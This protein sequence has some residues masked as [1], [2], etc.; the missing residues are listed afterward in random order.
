[1]S[2]AQGSVEL[3]LLDDDDYMHPVEDV[4][5]FNESAYYN[6]FDAERPVGGWV[7]IGNRPNEGYAEVTV[8][9]YEP[10]GTASFQFKRPQIANNDAHDA[11]GVRFQVVEPWKHHR[12]TY[13]GN[14]CFLRDP[15]E[16]AEPSVAFKKNPHVPVEL[17]L[18]W[19]GLS[20]GWGGEPRR[21]GPGGLWEP[22]RLGDPERQFARGHFEQHGA[23]EGS[24]EI[25]GRRYELRGCGLRDHSWGPRF[26]QNTGYYR[27]LTITLGP[28]FGLM[29]LVSETESGEA[30]RG[31]VYRRGQPNAQVSKVELHTDFGGPQQ[32]QQQIRARLHTE[33]GETFDVEGRVLSLVP[34]RNRRQGW[35]T[36]ISEGMTEWH[37]SGHR[38]YGMSEYLDH[39][40]KGA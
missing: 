29:G 36:R 38:G 1:M 30:S 4:G 3:V 26:W 40:E 35:I 13:A 7:R 27:W 21:R 8:C 39:L 10:D 6:F 5:H 2:E 28:D 33:G 17:E 11:G 25:D 34:C 19:R 12:V 23:V 15:L 14:V 32:T 37:C 16:M 18:D 9:L 22:A 31:Y 24:L 20:P